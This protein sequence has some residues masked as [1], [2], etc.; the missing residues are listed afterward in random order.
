MSYRVLF[1]LYLV[2]M[3]SDL[4]VCARRCVRVCRAHSGTI[5]QLEQARFQRRFLARALRLFWAHWFS[6]TRTHSHHNTN[7]P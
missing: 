1:L 7:T 5:V 2:R 3:M 6:L 4:R